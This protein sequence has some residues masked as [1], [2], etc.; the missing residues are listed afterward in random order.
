MQ[1]RIAALVLAPLLLTA[2]CG[3]IEGT[4]G[5]PSTP[6]LPASSAPIATAS[7]P[8]GSTVPSGSQA[9]AAPCRTIELKISV[10]GAPGGGAAGSQYNWLVFTNVSARTC[11]LYGYPG[12]ARLAGPA[13]PQVNDPLN[14]MAAT[15]PARVVL[16]PQAAAHA[17]IQEGHPAAFEPACHAVDIAGL[18]VYP[19]DE[20]AA[21]FV[22]FTE[23]A[24]SA[25]GVNGGFVAPIEAGLGE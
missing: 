5:Q 14:H 10:Q 9:E 8:P 2:G 21:V 18:R 4:S 20:T 11:S 15:T 17:V 16:A 6:S 23:R 1:R 3:P 12:V 24:C 22:P 13:G 7:S 19:P 25:K